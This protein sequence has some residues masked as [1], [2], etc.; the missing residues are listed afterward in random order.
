MLWHQ[1][2]QGPPPLRKRSSHSREGSRSQEEKEAAPHLLSPSLKPERIG[3]EVEGLLNTK[4]EEVVQLPE[5]ADKGIK[6]SLWCNGQS[7]SC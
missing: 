2:S 4:T 6:I 1:P 3:E 5:Y 7:Y